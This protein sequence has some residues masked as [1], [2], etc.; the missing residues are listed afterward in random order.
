MYVLVL[1]ITPELSRAL[2]R[3]LIQNRKKCVEI[4]PKP[5]PH[6]PGDREMWEGKR[7]DEDAGREVQMQD[8]KGLDAG[9]GCEKK[10]RDGKG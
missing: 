2:E 1:K 5:D 7:R 9:A 6:L 4:L 10:I 8:R 3:R